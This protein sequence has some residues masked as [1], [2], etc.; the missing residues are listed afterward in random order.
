M[1]GWILYLL[2]PWIFKSFSL[3]LHIFRKWTG[4]LA[5]SPD[6]LWKWI[7]ACKELCDSWMEGAIGTEIIIKLLNSAAGF[8]QSAANNCVLCFQAEQNTL[9][10]K[11]THMTHICA[12]KAVWKKSNKQ[13]SSSL[14]DW[15]RKQNSLVVLGVMRALKA[16][17]HDP[18]QQYWVEVNI[19]V[20]FSTGDRTESPLCSVME[21]LSEAIL[22]WMRVWIG[23]LCS[24]FQTWFFT[25][26]PLAG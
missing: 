14:E 11:G 8:T 2:F 24:T 17:S 19:A 21:E 5:T 26:S 9:P 25:R 7:N 12:L 3:S 22:A 10:T 20:L 15:L 6:Y 4:F 16:T 23:W 1:N 18:S 13:T